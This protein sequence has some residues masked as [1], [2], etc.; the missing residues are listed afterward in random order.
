MKKLL[1]AL[2]L[3]IALAACNNPEQNTT[4]GNT[5][6]SVNNNASAEVSV[7]TLPPAADS[8]HQH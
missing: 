7:D 2:V 8:S 1:T 4:T 3:V 5:V 6:D